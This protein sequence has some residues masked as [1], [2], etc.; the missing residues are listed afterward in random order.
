MRSSFVRNHNSNISLPRH[1]PPS[2]LGVILH[3][4]CL[5]RP[6]HHHRAV[7]IGAVQRRQRQCCAFASPFPPPS[8]LSSCGR[9][10]RHCPASASAST[11]AS[12][13]ASAFVAT[14]TTATTRRSHFDGTTSTR[15]HLFR[16][17]RKGSGSSST[18][19]LRGKSSFNTLEQPSPQAPT[20]TMPTTTTTSQ[21]TSQSTTTSPSHR[22][23][24]LSKISKFAEPNGD[25]LFQFI[26]KS[27]LST[28]NPDFGNFLDAGTGSHSLRWIASVIH[29]RQ[30]LENTTTTTE[31]APP[32]TETPVVAMASYTAITADDTMRNNVLREA[33]EL[34]IEE[35]GD[36]LIG[37]WADGVERSGSIDPIGALDPV[38]GDDSNGHYDDDADDRPK[39]TP[40]LLL[41]N[42]T[43][44]TILADY[45]VGAIDGF[46]PYFQDLIFHR[47]SPHLAP[48]GRLYVIG[49]QPLPDRVPGD[50]NVMCKIA[51][52][53]DACIL[54]A[55]HRCYREFPLD[56]ILRHVKRAG[57][58]VVETRTYPIRYDHATM[59]RQINV[60][61][62]KLRWFPSEGMAEEMRKVLDGLEKESLEVTKRVA[63]GRVTLGYD[64]VVVAEKPREN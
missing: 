12:T 16:R 30:I 28:G 38:D 10:N 19:E 23:I 49:L 53:R 62:S 20:M 46:S 37:N 61:R 15:R 55:N 4:S 54:L 52:V 14:T 33:R 41:R 34:D 5:L 2:I 36:V 42:R 50:A 39:R 45:L 57:L 48:G 27:Q 7:A 47:L 64:Y 56:W 11:S 58:T 24:D 1:S 60:A 63:G 26:E 40:L 29:R 32:D 22:Q 8:F 43:Y 35:Y 18:E 9:D 13:S 59:V 21:S 44:Q 25:V 6:R 3:L 31:A 17:K 51:K